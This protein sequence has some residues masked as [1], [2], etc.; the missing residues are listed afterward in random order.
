MAGVPGWGSG[1]L[2]VLE[3]LVLA[4]GVAWFLHSLPGG[5]EELGSPSPEPGEPIFIP[6]TADILMNN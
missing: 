3:L 6:L 2:C 4:Q 1:E 5:W